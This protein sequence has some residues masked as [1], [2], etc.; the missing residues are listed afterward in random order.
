MQQSA[1]PLP[2]SPF[3]PSLAPF[4]DNPLRA[5][6]IN[7]ERFLREMGVKQGDVV[8]EVGC[9]PGFFTTVLSEIVGETGRVYAQDVEE[10][11]IGRLKKK[12][13]GL[14]SQNII[15]LLCNSSALEL[16]DRSCDV[17]LCIN[18]IEEIDKEGEMESTIQELD[19]VLKREGLVA[20]K[21]HRLGGT[22]PRI[23]KAE[24][25]LR[26]LGYQKVF[27]EKTLFSYHAK[28]RRQ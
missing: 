23:Q 13:K 26:S 4:L 28:M 1:K 2:K 20:I 7:R 17:V 19:R 24:A 22:W 5:I 16:P 3:P 8:L 10:R 25:L 6:L 9:G 12:L 14:R 21:E 27:E 15:L 11:M 18:V